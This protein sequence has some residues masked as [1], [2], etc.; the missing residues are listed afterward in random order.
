MT[1]LSGNLFEQDYIAPTVQQATEPDML[2]REEKRLSV[3]EDPYYH[4]VGRRSVAMQ[5]AI[6]MAQRVAC[7]TITVLLLGET[8]TGKEMFARAIHAGSKRTGKFV[9][10]NCAAI[11][12]TLLESELFGYERGAFSGAVTAQQGLFERAD[13][14]TIFLDEI[15]DM[16][17]FLQSKLLRVLQEPEIYRLG[18]RTPRRVDVRIIAATNQEP[19][20]LI[21][22]GR[23]REDLYHRLN[24]IVIN[25][26]PLRERQ[27]DLAPLVRFFLHRFTTESKRPAMEITPEA[28]E[29]LCAYDWPGNVRELA[30]V[31]KRAVVLSQG[32]QVTAQDL[33]ALVAAPT[34][35][36]ALDSCINELWQ[37]FSSTDL[38]YY[39]VRTAI[40]REFLRCT[41]AQY[42]GNCTAAAR[43]LGLTPTYMHRLLKRLGVNK[44]RATP[45]ISDRTRFP[46]Y[47]RP[48]SGPQAYASPGR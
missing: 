41:L 2:K 1:V 16:P 47:L 3:V 22:A 7:D 37:V 9:P 10:I 48:V 29:L 20:A 27:E 8:G 30:N 23:F 28:Q 42:D 15:G 4:I 32:S 14:G 45:P 35:H 31:I 24:G 38:N 19:R 34:S 25:L 17:L 40:M 11:P 18:A 46:S 33:S 12:D 13:G 26:P 5:R 21:R 43:A 44:A 36:V 6:T 39:T